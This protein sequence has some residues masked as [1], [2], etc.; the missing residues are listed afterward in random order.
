LYH[1]VQGLSYEGTVLHS[2]PPE[3]PKYPDPE[4]AAL[5]SPRPEPPK[6]PG[7]R[8]FGSYLRSNLSSLLPVAAALLVLVVVRQTMVVAHGDCKAPSPSAGANS[9]PVMWTNPVLCPDAT[10]MRRVFDGAVAAVA[11]LPGKPA[12]GRPATAAEKAKLAHREEARA[13]SDKEVADA[14]IELQEAKR[15]LELVASAKPGADA[16]PQP[17]SALPN[18]NGAA[19]AKRVK[20]AP[21]SNSADAAAAADTATARAEAEVKVSQASSKLDVAEKKKAALI[22]SAEAIELAT[23]DAALLRETRARVLWFGSFGLSLV[24]TL[25]TIGAMVWAWITAID[26][27]LRPTGLPMNVWRRAELLPVLLLSAALP[28]AIWVVAYRLVG[29][30][31][32][33]EFPIPSPAPS[34]SYDDSFQSFLFGSDTKNLVQPGALFQHGLSLV[35]RLNLAVI[36]AGIAIAGAVTATLYQH[37]EQ[38]KSRLP[39]QAAAG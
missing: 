2:Q 6:H 12:E 39:N 16:K 9:S 23:T 31:I 26:D 22:A 17:R 33:G 35:R 30:S 21:A 37:P 24:V 38:V 27:H 7:I 4:D 13:T 1:I 28:A 36:L 29:T 18:A 8:R 20:P 25:G 10:V 11:A 14:R 5:A 32:F 3:P 19:A 15:K 34:L